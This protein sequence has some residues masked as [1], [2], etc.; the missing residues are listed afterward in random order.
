MLK[1]LVTFHYAGLLIGILKGY[2]YWLIIIPILGFHPL[3]NPTNRGEMITVQLVK[4]IF[5]LA[6]LQVVLKE[7]LGETGQCSNQCYELVH[8]GLPNVKDYLKDYL[9]GLPNVDDFFQKIPLSTKQ[10]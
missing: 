5:F 1:T 4:R 10:T 3:Y 7:I 8:R 9:K 2:L 6:T